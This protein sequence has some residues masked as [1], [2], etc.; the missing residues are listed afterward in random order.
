MA[1]FLYSFFTLKKLN[2]KKVLLTLRLKSL[3][4]LGAGLLMAATTYA[5]YCIPTYSTGTGE[6]DFIGYVGLGDISNTTE[7]AAS[8]FYTDFTAMSTDLETGGI[9]TITLGSGSYGSSNDLYAWIDYNADMDFY[10]AGEFLG[11]V[12]DLGAYAT[13]SFSFTVPMDA[14]I[15][16]TRLRVREI[17]AGLAV[18]DNCATYSYGETEDYSVNI[19]LGGGGGET[20][21]A[22]YIYSN[23]FGIEPWGS[24]NNTTSMNLAF[25][26]EGTGWERNYFETVDV[27]SVFSAENC[28]VF[29]EGSD[30]MADEMEAF[31]TANMATIEGWVAAGGNLLLNSAPNEGDGMSFGFGGTSLVYS[32]YTSDATAVD[33]GHPIFNGPF[34]PAGTY[35][36]GTSFGHARVTGT[37]LT[38]VMVDAFAASNVVVAEKAWG[39]GMVMFGGMTTA[40]WHSPVPNADNLRAN[41]F[42]YLSCEAPVVCDTPTG[43]FVDGVTGTTANLYWDAVDGAVG[44]NVTV[45]NDD[46]NSLVARFQSLTNSAT[47]T[48]LTP[49][50]NY[51]FRVKTVCIPYSLTSAISDKYYFSTPGKLGS[52]SGISVFPNPSNGFFTLNLNGYESN[53]F[54]LSVYNSIG[55]VVYQSDISVTSNSL[56]YELNLDNLAPGMY[57]MTL[58]NGENHL[59]YPVMIQK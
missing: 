1:G 16:T 37:G 27:G 50:V 44:Y 9:Y 6:G 3:T 33:A 32:Y 38:D 53:E 43:L 8:P 57:H 40:N 29:L 42:S 51:G 45:R 19:A 23:V 21:T 36:T 26:P 46:D 48:G 55:E 14:A 12:Q 39:D 20:P 47:V 10:D 30:F 31:L 56:T 2:M 54:N 59:S 24:T 34:T 4:V 41:M 35:F 7:G 22:H 5:Q 18:P 28:F 49:G 13:G 17:W 58:V 15:G 25:G 52:V 11:T